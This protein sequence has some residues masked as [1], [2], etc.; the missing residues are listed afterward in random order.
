MSSNVFLIKFLSK[1]HKYEISRQVRFIGWAFELTVAP[2]YPS[3]ICETTDRR[4]HALG[5]LGATIRGGCPLW[6]YL[7][8]L[9]DATWAL[10]HRE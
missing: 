7:F 1:L 8:V 9:M 6:P 10:F 4:V 3:L 2:A 5:Q